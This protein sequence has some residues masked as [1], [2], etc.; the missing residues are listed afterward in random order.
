MRKKIYFI[1]KSGGMSEIME[2]NVK[3]AVGAERRKVRVEKLRK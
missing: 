2:N 3:C 1:K